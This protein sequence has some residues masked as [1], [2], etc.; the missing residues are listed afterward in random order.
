MNVFSL[1]LFVS[2]LTVH[3]F[4]WNIA[5]SGDKERRKVIFSEYRRMK[6][7]LTLNT[8]RLYKV[9]CSYKP[10]MN[11]KCITFCSCVCVQ[12]ADICSTYICNILSV[13]RI[14]WY[15]IKNTSL[16]TNYDDCD[17]FDSALRTGI[18]FDSSVDMCF[19]FEW[20]QNWLFS[21]ALSYRVYMCA[22]TEF[23]RIECA[24]NEGTRCRM[25][26][27][28]RWRDQTER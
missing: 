8:H 2:A 7:S 25:K 26:E 15:C 24:V 10:E 28:R 21:G 11:S 19:Q 13:E 27:Q 1:W 17:H 3:S 4:D 22:H 14:M 18:A 23:T 5:R 6:K 12:V 20:K 9:C 16:L